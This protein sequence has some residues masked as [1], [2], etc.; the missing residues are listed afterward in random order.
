[1]EDYHECRLKTP[2]GTVATFGWSTTD[3]VACMTQLRRWS[4]RRSDD[5]F[6]AELP[7]ALHAMCALAHNEAS[8]RLSGCL[9]SDVGAIHEAVHYLHLTDEP[10]VTRRRVQ[11]AVTHFLNK[12][13]AER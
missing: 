11:A 3:Y 13:E 7:E 8:H 12:L 5:K 4:K 1:M 6:R 9:L 2:D 10:L